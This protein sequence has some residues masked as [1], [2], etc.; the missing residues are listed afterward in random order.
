MVGVLEDVNV[1]GLFIKRLFL[2]LKEQVFVWGSSEPVFSW[3]SLLMLKL[4]IHCDL[5]IS[6]VS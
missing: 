5:G 6:N 1:I 4:T 3:K 2:L